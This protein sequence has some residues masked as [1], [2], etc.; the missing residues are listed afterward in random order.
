[1]P[2]SE[3][4][5][6]FTNELAFENWWKNYYLITGSGVTVGDYDDDGLPDIFLGG[7]DSSSRL[8]RQVR[9]WAFE[10]VTEAAGIPLDD[11]WASGAAFADMDND[12]DLD[13]LVTYRG[14]PNRYYINRGD[15][16]FQGRYF[17]LEEE[18]M[19]PSPTMIAVID[20][21]R[22]GD[23]DAYLLG[24]RLQRWQEEVP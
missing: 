8:F 15:G 6:S 10:D 16:T 23:L 5:L 11:G 2:S 4:G 19:K 18:G 20:A 13:L 21:D 9:P 3:T 1:M 22:D 14:S 24:Y 12:G 7:Q 17:V